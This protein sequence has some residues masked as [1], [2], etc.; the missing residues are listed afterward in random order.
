MGPGLER[1][2]FDVIVDV[3]PVLPGERSRKVKLVQLLVLDELVDHVVNGDANILLNVYVGFSSAG[4]VGAVF[5]YFFPRVR[6]KQKYLI[7]FPCDPD[8]F[9]RKNLPRLVAETGQQIMC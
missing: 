4:H 7:N 3:G 9:H 1:F 5:V 8:G 6:R 2:V